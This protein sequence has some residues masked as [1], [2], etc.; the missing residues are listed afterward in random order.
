MTYFMCVHQGLANVF[1][2]STMTTCYSVYHLCEKNKQT[3]C[4]PV[5][6]ALVYPFSFSASYMYVS[7]HK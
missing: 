5:V 7:I 4:I 3:D 1:V 6:D 2:Y